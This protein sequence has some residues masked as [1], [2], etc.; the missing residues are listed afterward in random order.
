M[1]LSKW[2]DRQAEREDMKSRIGPVCSVVLG[3][4]RDVSEKIR[5]C[6]FSGRKW[7][8]FELGSNE[9]RDWPLGRMGQETAI[10]CR[11]VARRGVQLTLTTRCIIGLAAATFPVTVLR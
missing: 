11:Q 1:Y 9:C 4:N 2:K 6:P 7:G 5:A 8:L 3:P 10:V